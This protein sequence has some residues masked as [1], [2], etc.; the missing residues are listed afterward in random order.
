MKQ[1]ETRPLS[2]IASE[3]RR[4]WTKVNY[5]AKPYLDAMHSLESIEEPYMY[6]TGKSIVLYFLS[7]AST[8]RGAKAREIKA[9]LKAML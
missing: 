3:I 7:N 5:A 9:E 6:D 4:D 8:W 2:L 1:S